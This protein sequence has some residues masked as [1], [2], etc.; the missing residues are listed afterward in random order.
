MGE[1]LTGAGRQAYDRG[2]YE[3]A[4]AAFGQA[5]QELGLLK[6]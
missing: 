3:T 4:V 1:E 5:G 2:E 6:T